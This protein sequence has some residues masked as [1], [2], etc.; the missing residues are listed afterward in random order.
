M[1][2]GSFG[3]HAHCASMPSSFHRAFLTQII[4][5]AQIQGKRRQA[6]APGASTVGLSMMEYIATFRI[7]LI[8]DICEI[9]SFEGAFLKGRHR[10]LPRP[11]KR[12]TSNE[13][14]P[15]K[16]KGRQR[17]AAQGSG[18]G[19]PGSSW[20]WWQHSSQH[21]AVKKCDANEQESIMDN[22]QTGCVVTCDDAE[23]VCYLNWEGKQC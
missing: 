10:P 5:Y 20:Q 7:L 4:D 8:C 1:K 15:D 9:K 14:P 2:F 23:S 18:V 12:T 13:Q 21:S 11:P 6:Q 19:R 16:S 22:A 17:S 3:F